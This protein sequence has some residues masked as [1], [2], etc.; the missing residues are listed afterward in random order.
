MRKITCI[1]FV[2]MTLM[3]IYGTGSLQC[4]FLETGRATSNTFTAFSST[5]WTQTTRADFELGVLFQVDTAKSPGDVQLAIQSGQNRFSSG[6][7]ASQVLNTGKK[8]L[9]LDVFAWT[10]TISPQTSLSF[11]IRASDWPFTPNNNTLPWI[12]LG[13]TTPVSGGLPRGQYVQ[14]RANFS[15]TDKHQTPVLQSVE[16]WYH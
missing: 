1:L 15:T 10:A 3:I 7:L 5:V 16:V 4:K 8:G 6:S 14:W 13:S 11:N 2:M 9:K 12:A